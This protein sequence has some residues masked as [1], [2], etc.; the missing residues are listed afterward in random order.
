MHH[1]CVLCA[2]CGHSKDGGGGSCHANEE[3]SG[4]T[5]VLPSQSAPNGLIFSSFL[6]FFKSTSGLY[7]NNSNF[8]C[9]R[10][11]LYHS[12]IT[13]A[14][15]NETTPPGVETTTLVHPPVREHRILDLQRLTPRPEPVD[16]LGGLGPEVF[17]LVP[18]R[19]EG[20]AV[21]SVPG[22]VAPARRVRRRRR[23]RCFP[24]WCPLP[25][26]RGARV[27]AH[28]ESEVCVHVV[29]VVVVELFLPAALQPL[30]SARADCNFPLFSPPPAEEGP[31]AQLPSAPPLTYL[32]LATSSEAT[33]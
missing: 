28:G 17:R 13:T 31:P 16:V 5:V 14:E 4:A 2:A 3:S 9:C 20:S 24:A 32:T 29:V 15:A 23:P 18:G 30:N 10:F 11:K 12:Y 7:N 26:Q 19:G 22:P 1:V 6:F 21:R 25:L 33:T 8:F 27:Q